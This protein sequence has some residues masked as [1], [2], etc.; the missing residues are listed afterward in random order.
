MKKSVNHLHVDKWERQWKWGW[1]TVVVI[2]LIAQLLE[3]GHL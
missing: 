1:L 2:L 3:T